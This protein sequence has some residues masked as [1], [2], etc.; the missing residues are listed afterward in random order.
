MD[1]VLSLFFWHVGYNPE[2][3]QLILFDVV[4]SGR[5]AEFCIAV[6]AVTYMAA[7]H[8]MNPYM[9]L[10]LYRQSYENF[11]KISP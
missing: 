9:F 6:R 7:Y 1:D 4:E 10:Y 3:A 11:L 5:W 8:D 2:Q